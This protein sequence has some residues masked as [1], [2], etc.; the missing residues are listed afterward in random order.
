M[1]VIENIY[2]PI[3]YSKKKMNNRYL[4]EIETIMEELEIKHLADTKIQYLSGGEKQRV[5]IVRALSL[6]LDIILA[7]EPMGNLDM[8]NSN[9]TFNVLKKLAGEGKTL[10]LVTHNLYENL[11]ADRILTLQNGGLR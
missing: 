6:K 10:I 5:S 8:A 1:T 4:S 9:I 11:G 7:D 2:M 3:L